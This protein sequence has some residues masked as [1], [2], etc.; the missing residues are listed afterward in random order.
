MQMKQ[1]ENKR[2][3]HQTK[4]MRP[5]LRWMNDWLDG[6]VMMWMWFYFNGWMVEWLYG[7]MDGW[8]DEKVL[9]QCDTCCRFY[10][11]EQ[12]KKAVMG[13]SVRFETPVTR[14]AWR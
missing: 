1:N 2:H 5:Y 12:L 6:R 11:L 4:L 7:W 10:L 9:R 14:A 8:M 3:T 13:G